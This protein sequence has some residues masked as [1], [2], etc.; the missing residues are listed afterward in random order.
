[1]GPRLNA[2][3][4]GTGLVTTAA[5]GALGAYAIS[6]GAQGGP[7]KTVTIDVAT[8]PKGDTGPTGPPG[9]KGDPGPKGETG[10]RGPAGGVTCPAGYSEG[11]LVINHPG[12]QTAI[13]TCLAD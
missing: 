2:V 1:M 6:A 4:L 3:L 13:W 8:G 9:P 12:G 10:P 5:G 7:A 11:R